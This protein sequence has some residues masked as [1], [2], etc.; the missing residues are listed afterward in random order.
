MWLA[1]HGIPYD[2]KSTAWHADFESKLSPQ[3][4]FQFRQTFNRKLNEKLDRGGGACVFRNDPCLTILRNHML[5]G[6]TV[7]YHLGD[8]VIMP[9]HVHL[10]LNLV[11]GIELDKALHR[12]KSG[13]AFL[14]NQA[15]GRKGKLWQKESYDHLVRD[16]RELRSFRNY[17]RNNPDKARIAV[18]KEGLYEAKWLVPAPHR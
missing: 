3:E 18:P 5:E 9:N 1:A 4:R 6:D 12:I 14:C 10:L 13:S 15:L 11:A 17:I 7:H 16:S 2:P 8:F